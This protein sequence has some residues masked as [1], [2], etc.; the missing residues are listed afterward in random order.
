MRTN[1][2]TV[3][4]NPYDDPTVLDSSTDSE[5]EAEANKDEHRDTVNMSVGSPSP[6]K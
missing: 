1:W 4:W 3:K 6:L 2:K 5:D